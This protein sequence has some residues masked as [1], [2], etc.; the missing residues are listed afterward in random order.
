MTYQQSLENIAVLKNFIRIYDKDCIFF[1]YQ[2]QTEFKILFF[3]QDS[4][5]KKIEQMMFLKMNENMPVAHITFNGEIERLYYNDT[6]IHYEIN[7][8]TS[9][10]I[11]NDSNHDFIKQHSEQI[12]LQMAQLLTKLKQ[13]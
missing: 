13:M 6:N 8:I 2:S 4:D 12:K 11:C 3:N 5:V 1:D 7:S 10:V 9:E